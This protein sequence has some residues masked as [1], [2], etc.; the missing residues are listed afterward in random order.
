MQPEDESTLC[1]PDEILDF[2]REFVHKDIHVRFEKRFLHIC[3]RRRALDTTETE[4]RAI[5]AAANIGFSRMP[6]DGYSAPAAI[7]MPTVL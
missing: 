6:K 5:A 1:E 4:L 7:G 3:L 2:S